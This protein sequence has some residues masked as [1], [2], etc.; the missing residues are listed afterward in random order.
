[1]AKIHDIYI[2]GD[3]V[4][5]QD[6]DAK[7]WGMVNLKDVKDQMKEGK[8]ADEFHV[9]INSKGGSVDEGFAMHDLLKVS[10]KKVITYVEGMCA[11]IATIIFLAGEERHITENSTGLIHFPMA[12]V[13][14]T[15]EELEDAAEMLQEIQD[16]IIDT[17][18]TVTGAD[19]AELVALMEAEDRLDAEKMKEL[20]FATNI[21]K[22]LKAVAIINVGKKDKVIADIIKKQTAMSKTFVKVEGVLSQIL[23]A[24]NLKEDSA[25]PVEN[26]LTLTTEDGVKLVILTGEQ[27]AEVGDEVRVDNKVPEDGKFAMAN[28]E[29]YHVKG[30]K[31]EK[32][33]EAPKDTVDEPNGELDKL[34]ADN[35]VLANKI[36]VLEAD[37]TTMKQTHEDE[38]KEVNTK[39]D[40]IKEGLGSDYKPPEA[41]FT[42]HQGEDETA[43][44]AAMRR[45][46]E[47][48]AEKKE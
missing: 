28:K 47:A 4:G 35:K 36:A 1:M 33:D 2:Y 20:G 16:K 45:K 43:V 5:F 38:L 14:G 26:N 40:M 3:I 12:G 27:K 41:K 6:E 44:Q 25:K 32:I 30:G 7:K 48:K 19:K 22:T 37:N 46:R 42:G 17:Y 13:M 11:S 34:K 39:L 15:A 24:M 18:V 21:I 31:I 10:G 23:V 29:T 9:H 8:D